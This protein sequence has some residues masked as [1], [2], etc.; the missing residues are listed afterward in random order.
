MA[1]LRLVILAGASLLAMPAQADPVTRWRPYT[2]EASSRFGVPL[3]WIERV[4]AAESGGMTRLDGRPITS[5]AGAMGL[6]QLMPDT[7]AELR[8]ALGLGR[9]THDPHDNII[10]GTYYLRLMYRRFGYPGLFAAYN[11]G[12]ARYTAW[13]SGRSGLPAETR[14]YVASVAGGPREAG[15]KPIVSP[16][17][18][19]LFAVRYATSAASVPA[20]AGPSDALFVRLSGR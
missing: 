7:W 14:A 11:A 12:P 19:S 15:T 16:A 13:L 2:E 5:P 18:P 8:T 20:A 10:A 17:R 4:M 6:M 9:D 1:A 3:A